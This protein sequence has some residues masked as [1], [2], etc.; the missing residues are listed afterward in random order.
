MTKRITGLK[1]LTLT[2]RTQEWEEKD[3]MLQSFPK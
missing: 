2:K 3:A 1:K